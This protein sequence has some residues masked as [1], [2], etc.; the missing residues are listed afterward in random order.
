MSLLNKR[1]A[2]IPYKTII[3]ATLQFL[4]GSTLI[5]TGCLL[6]MGCISHMGTSQAIAI[7]IVGFL[8]FVPECYHLIIIC[9]S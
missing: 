9:R 7:L 4:I 8:V 1:P 6:L 5:M 2:K 3:C